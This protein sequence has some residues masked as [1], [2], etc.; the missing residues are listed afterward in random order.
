VPADSYNPL[1]CPNEE[2]ALYG[3]RQAPFTGVFHGNGK[4]ISGLVLSGGIAALGDT[5]GVYAGAVYLGLFAYVQGAYIHDLTIEIVNTEE[6]A[7]IY[8]GEDEPSAMYVAALAAFANNSRIEDV[9]VGSK[10]GPLTVGS[11]LNQTCI[12]GIA[13]LARGSS[14]SKVASAIPFNTATKPDA[15]QMI[16]G[17]AGRLEGPSEISEAR[18]TG[19]I[20]VTGE[21]GDIYAGGL[22]GYATDA[23]VRNSEAAFDTMRIIHKQTMGTIGALIYAG[24]IGGDTGRITECAAAFDT[25]EV[26]VESV[27]I[28]GIS[29]GGLV[30]DGSVE[31]SHV[32]F[33]RIRVT[34]ELTSKPGAS[35]IGGLAGNTTSVNG[36]YIEGRGRIVVDMSGAAYSLSVGGLAGRAYGLV[37]R[38]RIPEGID[39]ELDSGANA[40]NNVGGLIGEGA[41]QYC[42][43]GAPEKHAS[44]RVTIPSLETKG[45][46]LY[47]GGISGSPNSSGSSSFQ[48]NYVFCDISVELQGCVDAYTGGLIGSLY[49]P[50]GNNSNCSG[51]YAV[52][53]LTITNNYTSYLRGAVYAGGIAGYTRGSFISNCAALGGPLT[54]DGDN[55]T[56]EKNWRRIAYPYDTGT[57]FSG[58]I[59]TIQGSPPAAYTVN[60]GPDTAD[61]ELKSS[62][63][64]A[65][66]EGLGWDFENT[67]DWDGEAGLPVFKTSVFEE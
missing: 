55:S 39:I 22:V 34:G 9:G 31:D 48:Y 15:D 37:S 1:A 19:D 53:T 6:E 33:N 32:R 23:L 51:S 57:P 27:L 45:R 7:V 36:S 44:V 5:E 66:F 28:G 18:A 30:G 3:V 49:S 67:W 52:G 14:L 20:L 60:N 38:S 54:I 21:G 13:G 61:G 63:S 40:I 24:G 50:Y 65:D 10:N 58:N 64:R 17:I 12:G 42:F 59:T 43:S 11:S 35:Y 25:L 41:A 16:G 8:T 4:K 46:G 47:A 62:I 26:A 29:A 2:C 56:A